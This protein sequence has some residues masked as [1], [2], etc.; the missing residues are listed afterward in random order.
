MNMCMDD[1][2]KLKESLQVRRAL[3]PRS[4]ILCSYLL[5]IDL[6]DI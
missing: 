2:Q 5:Y 4:L 1:W 3:I 6:A